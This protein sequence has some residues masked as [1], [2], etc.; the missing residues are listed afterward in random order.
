[1]KK[2]NVSDFKLILLDLDGTIYIGKTVIP[3]AAETILKLR[4]LGFELRFLTN[5]TTTPSSD[6]R[7]KLNSYQIKMEDHE[8]ITAPIAAKL[9]LNSIQEKSNRLIRIWPVVADSIK[10]EFHDYKIETENP[11]Y[12]ILGDI[13]DAW[14]LTLIN[15]LFNA[16]H[17]G[18]EL[19]ALHK[20]RFWQ[21][22]RGLKVD[23]GFFVS[24]LEYVTSKKA[25][26]MGK[27]NSNFFKRVIE[28]AGYRI[29]QT[30]MVGDDIDTDIGGAQDLGING[31]LVK[32]GKFRQ[33]YFESS[34]IQPKWIIDSIAD[35]PRLL[36]R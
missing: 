23:I 16:L 12:I 6:I 11:D 27:P 35:L 20:N 25:L 15:D 18:A 14:N 24:G 9:E 32:T 4:E 13:G 21:T 28:S 2:K 34:L 19:I 22:E 29:D 8:L 26:I 7:S 3:G 31:A 17:N 1:M 30:I 33:N 10:G 36:T 5:T